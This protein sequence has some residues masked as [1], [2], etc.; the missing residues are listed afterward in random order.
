MN[1]RDLVSGSIGF[2]FGLLFIVMSFY[3]NAYDSIQNNPD[4]T[5]STWYGIEATEAKGTK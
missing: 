5:L 2:G 1:G 4:I 3:S